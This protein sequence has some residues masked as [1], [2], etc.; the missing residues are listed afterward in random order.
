TPRQEQAPVSTAANVQALQPK[1]QAEPAARASAEAAPV[2]APETPPVG[3]PR[4]AANRPAGWSDGADLTLHAMTA[5]A[6]AGPVSDGAALQAL[7][8][9][10]EAN[11]SMLAEV[12]AMRAMMKERFETI[13]F[14]EKLGRTPAQAGLAQKLMDGGFSTTLIRKMLD[15]M[16]EAVNAGTQDETQWASMV[17]ERNLH[18]A[19]GE[20][21]LEDRGGAIALI[22]STGVGKTTSTAKLAAMFAAKHGASNLGLITLD[23]YRVGA[24][25]QL[26][27]YGRILGVPVHMAHDRA[28]LEDL[29]ELL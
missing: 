18:T 20:P 3:K 16:H 7:K 14:V 15:A 21:A 23:A 8:L 12:R 10:Q 9:A 28:A 22:G 17:L 24:H 1:P 25:D 5:S 27:A 4:A 26:R 19:E 11:A 29:L 2:Q 13:A 6:S